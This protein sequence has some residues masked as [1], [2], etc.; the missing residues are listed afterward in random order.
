MIKIFEVIFRAIV[1]WLTDI[2]ND[3]FQNDY[4]DS[5]L[6]KIYIFFFVNGGRWSSHPQPSNQ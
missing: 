4:Y 3:K 1:P 5:Y 2:E 6:S